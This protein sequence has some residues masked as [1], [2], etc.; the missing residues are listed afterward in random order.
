VKVDN[1]GKN[2]LQKSKKTGGFDNRPNIFSI[3]QLPGNVNRKMSKITKFFGLFKK[4]IDDLYNI[5]YCISE[6]LWYYI[7]TKR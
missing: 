5:P 4:N 1:T 3:P 6:K 7:P 2:S